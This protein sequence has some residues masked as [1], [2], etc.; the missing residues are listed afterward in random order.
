MLA[1]EVE[2]APDVLVVEVFLI[3]E[4]APRRGGA[5]EDADGDVFGFLKF[6]GKHAQGDGKGDAR[7]VL[8][9]EGDRAFVNPPG[10]TLGDLY[11]QPHPS[12]DPLLEVFGPPLVQQT[13]HDAVAVLSTANRMLGDLQ[14]ADMADVPP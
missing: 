8:R 2:A 7:R 10:G 3:F 14:I 1:Q 13:A 5:V 6:E 12:G 11:R 9:P 4:V